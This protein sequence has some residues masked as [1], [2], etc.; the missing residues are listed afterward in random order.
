MSPVSWRDAQNPSPLLMQPRA[1]RLVGLTKCGIDANSAK[2]TLTHCGAWRSGSAWTSSG[3][4]SSLLGSVGLSAPIYQCVVAPQSCRIFLKSCKTTLNCIIE[5]TSSP[6]SAMC[7]CSG[8]RV[9]GSVHLRMEVV[10]ERFSPRISCWACSHQDLY[11]SV[12]SNARRLR[13][14]RPDRRR[15][16]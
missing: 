14:V 1:L 10:L 2:S 5:P 15:H 4:L 8:A 9:I 3:G 11:S 13:Q 6:S 16:P 12:F 7:H